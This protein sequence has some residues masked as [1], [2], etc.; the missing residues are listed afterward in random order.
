MRKPG[1][2]LRKQFEFCG[3]FENDARAALESDF[4]KAAVHA[5]NAAGTKLTAGSGIISPLDVLGVNEPRDVSAWIARGGAR[6]PPPCR[7][8]DDQHGSQPRHPAQP[9]A[10]AG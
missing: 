6:Q 9:A 5:Q 8:G 7:E 2:A 3:A 1:A 4:G 10:L